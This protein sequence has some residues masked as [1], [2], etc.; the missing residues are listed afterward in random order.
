MALAW[1]TWQ[2]RRELQPA[3]KDSLRRAYDRLCGKLAAVGLPRNAHEGAEDYAARIAQLRPDLAAA[4][5]GL[6]RRY[7]QLRYGAS[8]ADRGRLAFILRRA[9]VQAARFS[10]VLINSISGQ[11]SSIRPMLTR[12][13][14]R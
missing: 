9:R 2:V 8:Q 12:V 4:V 3:T 11:R 6:C 14:A 5:T 1:L 7:S 10:R 13:G